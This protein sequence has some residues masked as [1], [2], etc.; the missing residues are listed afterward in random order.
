MASDQKLEAQKKLGEKLKRARE[1]ANLTQAEVAEETDMTVTY[2]AMIERG[3]VNPSYDKL[4]KLFRLLKIN[5]SELP[6]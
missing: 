6:L 3:E 1:K 2:Y 5:L 4:R